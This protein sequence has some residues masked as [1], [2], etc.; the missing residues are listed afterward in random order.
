MYINSTLLLKVRSFHIY[1]VEHGPYKT[2]VVFV[3]GL[4]GCVSHYDCF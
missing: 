4:H 3:L 2:A 1:Y